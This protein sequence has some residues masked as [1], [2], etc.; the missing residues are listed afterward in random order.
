[1]RVAATE[2]DELGRV[3]GR[4]GEAKSPVYISH[5][6]QTSRQT[7]IPAHLI[8]IVHCIPRGPSGKE[9]P[10]TVAQSDYL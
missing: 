10:R 4:A 6:Q 3:A 2:A 5:H 9:N 1:M 7:I 8:S